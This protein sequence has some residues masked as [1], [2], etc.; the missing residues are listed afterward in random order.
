VRYRPDPPPSQP[1]LIADSHRWEPTPKAPAP[2]V[3]ARRLSSLDAQV[4][5]LPDWQRGPMRMHLEQVARTR[6]MHRLM[7]LGW[8]CTDA[9]NEAFKR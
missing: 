4:A 2:T 6:E 5:H 1:S 8:S 7:Q 3:K 9:A